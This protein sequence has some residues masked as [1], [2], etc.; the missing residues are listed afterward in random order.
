MP[1][2]EKRR[3]DNSSIRVRGKIRPSQPFTYKSFIRV[4]TEVGYYG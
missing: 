3:L 2:V 4:A 1:I